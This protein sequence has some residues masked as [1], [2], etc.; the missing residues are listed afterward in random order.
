MST[1]VITPRKVLRNCELHRQIAEVIAENP[2]CNRQ[3]SRL[4]DRL[5]VEVER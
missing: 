3:A 5:L 4:V 1:S 2:R